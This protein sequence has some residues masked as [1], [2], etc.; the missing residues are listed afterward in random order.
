M[1]VH[2]RIQISVTKAVSEDEINDLIKKEDIAI[3][4]FTS[5][6]EGIRIKEVS[7]EMND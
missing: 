5:A 2:A 7:K 6:L 4:F 1:C 3:H